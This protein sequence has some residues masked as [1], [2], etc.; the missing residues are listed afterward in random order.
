MNDQLSAR[1]LNP[2]TAGGAL[3]SS[4]GAGF[5][6]RDRIFKFVRDTLDSEQRVPILLLGQR[7]IGKSSILRQLPRHL[8][9]EIVCVYFDLQGK[10]NQTLDQVLY[11]LARAIADVVGI[12]A[13]S[14]DDAAEGSFVP[15]FLPRALHRLGSPRRLL[16]LFDEFDV[17]DPHPDLASTRFVPYI[18]EQLADGQIGLVLVMGRRSETMSETARAAVL[19]ECV[20]QRLGRLTEHETNALI[21]SL[22]TRPVRFSEAAATRVYRLTSGHPFC[23]QLL[24]HVVWRQ[25]VPVGDRVAVV[26]PTEVDEA[27]APTLELGANGMSW[28]YDGADQPEHRLLLSA[29]AES[30][31]PLQRRARTVRELFEVLQRERLSVPISDLE[32]AARELHEWDVIEPDGASGYRYVVPLLGAWV[33]T[34]RP[35]LF[36]QRE[37][38]FANPRA[39]KNYEL[40]LEALEH[41][42]PEEALGH[43]AIALRANPTFAEAQISLAETLESQ[44]GNPDQIVEAWERALELRPEMP[45]TSLLDALVKSI[46]SSFDTTKIKQRY[47]RITALDSGGAMQARAARA[48]RERAFKKE[49]VGSVPLLRE[50]WLLRHT[51]DREATWHEAVHREWHKTIG[52]FG[53]L[54]LPF[55]LLLSQFFPNPTVIIFTMLAS[56]IVGVMLSYIYIFDRDPKLTFRNGGGLFAIAGLLIGLEIW[57]SSQRIF[58]ASLAALLV[59][60]LNGFTVRRYPRETL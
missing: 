60:G 18:G 40:G 1:P 41:D 15:V 6:G 22:A 39:W 9:E 2:F 34:E 42:L 12:A 26:R 25:A 53:I 13:P 48:I 51:I 3:S 47:E 43:F 7:R 36:M 55:A 11:G 38:R 10:A 24:C 33:R 23:T 37:A 4:T 21:M 27:I 5:F 44:Q 35:L 31:N 20:Q 19:K 49:Q 14:R 58:L 30:G 56:A 46:E 29:L 8:G 32:R 59:G 52:G 16:L 54:M 17:V 57:S 28:I 45:Q 50:A